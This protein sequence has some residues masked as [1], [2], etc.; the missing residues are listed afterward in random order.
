MNPKD[1]L[2]TSII[3]YPRPSRRKSS[4]PWDAYDLATYCRNHACD[5]LVVPY[6]LPLIPPSLDIDDSSMAW[7]QVG[8]P[9]EDPESPDENAP[10]ESTLN[11]WVSRLQPL[12]DPSPGYDSS[13]AAAGEGKEVLFVS[14]NRVG[15]EEGQ[16]DRRIA[17]GEDD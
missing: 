10:R 11:Y 4:A 15:V 16:S 7:V 5:M 3:S 2:G 12:H 14:C 6:V 13:G 8:E 9:P 1:F 17:L